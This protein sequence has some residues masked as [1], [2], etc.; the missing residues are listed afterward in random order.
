MARPAPREASPLGRCVRYAEQDGEAGADEGAVGAA[1]ARWRAL[2]PNEGPSANE[3]DPS[4][5]RRQKGKMASPVG[6]EEGPRSLSSEMAS[7]RGKGRLFRKRGTAAL[8]GWRAAETCL[9]REGRAGS[10]PARACASPYPLL[11][12]THLSPK[13]IVVAWG[14]AG[15]GASIHRTRPPRRD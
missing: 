7:P 1:G 12:F 11:H 8:L 13:G 5:K 14:G 3:R 2:E 4:I 9:F 15:E 10:T 6:V